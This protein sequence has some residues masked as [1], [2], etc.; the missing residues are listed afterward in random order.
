MDD[1]PVF[2]SNRLVLTTVARA[3]NTG[4]TWNE[5]ELRPGRTPRSSLHDLGGAPVLLEPVR[6]RVGLSLW[7][8]E[9]LEV[10]ALDARGNGLQRVATELVDGK[11]WFDLGHPTLWYQIGRRR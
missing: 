3:E 5:P 11:L 1:Q 10:W 4:Q 8:M 7:N 9:N 2:T 6:G